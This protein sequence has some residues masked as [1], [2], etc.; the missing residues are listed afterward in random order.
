MFQQLNRIHHQLI[1]ERERDF[2]MSRQKRIWRPY[3]AGFTVQT[4]SYNLCDSHWPKA[5][6]QDSKLKRALT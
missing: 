1:E 3:T 2:E 6:T 5:K 4:M